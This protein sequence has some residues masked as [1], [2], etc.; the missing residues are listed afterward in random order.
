[1]QSR[2]GPIK[3]IARSRDPLLW[4]DGLLILLLLH[5]RLLLRRCLGRGNL[6]SWSL[7]SLAIPPLVLGGVLPHD[8]LTLGFRAAIF[9]RN[10]GDKL[11]IGLLPSRTS[12]AA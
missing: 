2:T 1:M 7:C 11:E 4:A 9:G 5:P 10:H 6:S 8:C 3:N 12:I